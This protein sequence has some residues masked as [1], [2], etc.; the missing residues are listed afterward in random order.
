MMERE[1]F[2][3]I[4]KLAAWGNDGYYDAIL[5]N[6]AEQR[7][8]VDMYKRMLEKRDCILAKHNLLPALE[9]S[10]ERNIIAEQRAE[11]ERKDIRIEEL[12][13]RI[14]SL[15][16]D[17]THLREVEGAA[18]ALSGELSRH[19]YQSEAIYDAHKNL[20]AALDGGK[21]GGA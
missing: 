2:E 6:D 16:T 21:G 10:G 3:K 17:L 5:A 1:E 20:K 7:A 19:N 4:V 12:E 18:K 11:L 14:E 9:E 8:D 13:G 15:K